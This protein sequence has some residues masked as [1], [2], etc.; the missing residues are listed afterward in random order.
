MLNVSKTVYPSQFGSLN[1]K[2]LSWLWEG[3]LAHG[4]TT[5]L[6]GRWYAGKSTLTSLLLARCATGGTFGG[7]ALKPC[8]ALVV[9][10]E[11][12]ELWEARHGELK[13]TDHVGFRCRPFRGK[14]SFDDWDSFILDLASEKPGLVVI[15][16]LAK[17][18]PCA[19]ENDSVGMNKSLDPLN[20]LTEEGAAVMINHHPAKA[21]KDSDLMGRGSGAL[22]A[23]VDIEATLTKPKDAA[24]N[25]I[26]R[27]TS[28]TRWDGL[29]PRIIELSSRLLELSPDGH[30]YTVVTA[31]P[32]PDSFELGWPILSM[33]LEDAG[34]RPTR[35]G[36]LKQWPV[37]FDKPSKST[38]VRWLERALGEKLIERK[39]TGRGHD[40]YRYNLMYQVFD[41]DYEY[42]PLPKR[43]W[44]QKPKPK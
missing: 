3:M 43:S 23:F 26:R 27:L 39:G 41:H 13:F 24:N 17:F 38:L 32:S 19:S 6:T 4:L 35:D 12:R 29:N 1:S 8:R 7:A 9:S 40:A 2:P 37:D 11:P 36:I 44:I 14:P 33:V 22:L 30:D 42:E 18:F 20:L 10:E 25:R 31:A 5:L 15:D 34:Q 16:P 28:Q 21:A